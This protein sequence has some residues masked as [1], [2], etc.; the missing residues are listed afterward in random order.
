MSRINPTKHSKCCEK[1]VSEI[2]S[3]NSATYKNFITL[4][5]K[6]QRKQMKVQDILT[7]I[8]NMVQVFNFSNSALPLTPNTRHLPPFDALHQ[9]SYLKNLGQTRLG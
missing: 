3:N 5:N 4:M 9:N 6:Y 2:R 1:F 7:Q 8:T